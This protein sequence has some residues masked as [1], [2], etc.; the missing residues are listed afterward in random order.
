MRPTVLMANTLNIF[1]S[2]LMPGQ[3]KVILMFNL[4]F[5]GNLVCS[6]NLR[7][8]VGPATG[9]I[10]NS[11]QLLQQGGCVEETVVSFNQTVHQ[12]TI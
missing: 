7:H 12:F 10:V 9:S 4:V 1:I 8:E 3:L 2:W 6:T 5:C 11:V